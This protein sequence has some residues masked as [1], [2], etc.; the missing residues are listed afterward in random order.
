MGRFKAQSGR[1]QIAIMVFAVAVSAALLFMMLAGSEGTRVSAQTADTPTPEATATPEP[2]VTAS[3]VGDSDVTSALSGEG[4][5]NPP[6]YSGMDSTL[7]SIVQQVEDGIASAQSA[8]SS[9][10]YSEEESVAVSLLVEEDSLEDVQQFLADNGADVRNVDEGYIEA[11][12]PV[13][14][15]PELSQQEGVT[16]VS[17]IVPPQ[18]LQT[19]VISEGVQ[20]HGADVWH[21]AR[22]KGDG[23]KIGIIDVGFEGFQDLM[24]SEL[25]TEANVHAL[26]FTELGQVSEDIVDCETF[27]DHGTYVTETAF[28]MAPNATYYISNAPSWSDLRNT[29]I[30]MISEDVDIIN[31]SVGW[32]WS[33]PGDGSSPIRTSPLNTVHLAAAYEILWVNAAGNSALTTWFGDYGD[34]DGDGLFNFTETDE[35]NDVLLESG[36]R[37]IAQLRWADVWLAPATDLDLFL[38]HKDTGEVVA[39]S[40]SFQSEFP[41]PREVIIFVPEVKGEYCLAVKHYAG[42]QAEWIQLNSFSKQDLEHATIFGSIAT[43]AE[44]NNPGMLAVGAAPWYDTTEIE[45][46]SSRGPT[47]DGRIKPDV[48]AADRGDTAS[49]GSFAGTSQAAPHVAGMAALLKQNFPT[50][51]PV[52]LASYFKQNALERGEVGPDNTWGYGFAVLP[53]SDA[54]FDDCFPDVGEPDESGGF[55]PSGTLGEG[56][57][58]DKPAERGSGDRYALYYTIDLDIDSEVTISL[59]SEDFDTYLYL[60][61]GFGTDGDVLAENDDAEGSDST[62]SGIVENLEAGEYTIEVTT[63]EARESGEFELTVTVIEK[64][65]VPEPEPEF[66]GG[67]VEVSYGSNHA[68]ALHEDGWIAC[69]GSNAHGKASPPEGEYKSVSSGEH[70]S[71]AIQEEDGKIVCWGIFEVGLDEERTRMKRKMTTK[72]DEAADG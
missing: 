41:I 36:E 60:L 10:P 4:K 26:C 57:V 48:V 66:E 67:F 43:P 13:S 58:T 14:L 2:T 34:N 55:S 61:E 33:G 44:S 23:I 5:V 6:Q 62:D 64:E 54:P 51:G 71:C 16:G 19:S 38:V 39:T 45:Y 47:P 24:G 12:V 52:E 25:P 49:I 28:D 18:P 53:V 7:N 70:G 1:K 32:L 15:L 27:D 40:E 29:V 46:F 63:F 30:W 68:C 17:T 8:A 65:I 11:Y 35:C 31:H 20:V 37:F 59:S 9:A 21:R 56:C 50:M 69:Y 42:P 3:G 72:S 22:V